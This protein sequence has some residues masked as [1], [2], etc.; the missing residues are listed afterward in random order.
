[1][2]VAAF[3]FRVEIALSDAVGLTWAS[4]MDPLVRVLKEFT[5]EDLCPSYREET[6]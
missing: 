1:M 2:A 3:G 4:S 5:K 6:F